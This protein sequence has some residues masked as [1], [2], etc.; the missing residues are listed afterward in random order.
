MDL[1]EAPFA[2]THRLGILP[3]YFNYIET[4]VKGYD[5][6]QGYALLA[7][8]DAQQRLHIPQGVAIFV[9]IEGKSTVKPDAAFIQGWYDKF[10]S[11][12]TYTIK[13]QKYTYQAG[14]YKA[15][16]YANT[17]ATANF[18]APF[19]AAVNLEPAIGTNSF[20]WTNQISQNITNQTFSEFSK[21]AKPQYQPLALSCANQQI[22]IPG[23]WQYGLEDGSSSMVDVDEAQPS[24]PLWYP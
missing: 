4:Q 14:Y 1:T 24:L 2:H 18:H 11:T 6:G 12:F 16:Y 19:C 21:A 20:I 23:A 8:K 22:P 3:I 10:N 15:G 13:G 5:T 7:I 17:G 9:D